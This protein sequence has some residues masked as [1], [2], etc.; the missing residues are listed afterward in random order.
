M[1]LSIQKFGS[2]HPIIILH[3]LYG[4]G[5]NWRTIGKALSG[6]G[7]VILVDQRNHG[8]SPHS[9]EMNYKVL[10]L[11]L[12]EL[13]DSLEIRKAVI[14]GHSM[15]GKAAMWFATENSG[16]VSR[17]IIADISPR[18]YLKDSGPSNHQEQ[19]DEILEALAG[20][21]LLNMAS[22]GAVD[23]L[24]EMALPG[25]RLRQFLL[26]NLQKNA[27]G[28]FEWKINIPSI[29]KNLG[30]LADGLD[31]DKLNGTEF[32]NFPIL[33]IKGEKSPYIL[34]PDIDL[35]RRLFPLAQITTIKNA[36]HWLH[37]EEPEVFINSV[38]KFLLT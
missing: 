14:I 37:A 10:A 4:C 38:K 35:I 22:I 33:F 21:D 31:L 34:E 25:K 12:K 6:I 23:K 24:L 2:G 1:Q 30:Y 26:K 17:L 36:G 15:G 32:K 13:M 9:D 8:A 7:E 28:Q 3:G 16:R 20:I 18:S 11:D 5:D 29:R 27:Q 19:H